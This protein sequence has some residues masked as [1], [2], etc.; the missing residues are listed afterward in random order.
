MM[1]LLLITFVLMSYSAF[2]ADVKE[3]LEK[4]Q[5]AYSTRV[6]Y[7]SVYKLYKTHKS[8]DVHSSYNGEVYG[9]DGLLYQKIK[10]TEFVYAKDF[11][12]KVSHE[13]RAMVLDM[14]QQSAQMEANLNK[15]LEQCSSSD[16]IEQDDYYTLIFRFKPTSTMPCSI[17]KL[18]VDKKKYILQ[19]MDIYYSYMQDFSTDYRTKDLSMPHLRVEFKETNLKPKA[20]EGIFEMATYLKSNKSMLTP[21][22]KCTGYELIDNRLN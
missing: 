4:V 12:I 20:R 3:V 15:A 22:G 5:Q 10:N 19:R 18:R 6:S 8:R 17:L 13:E 11:F 1:R 21:V 9:D 2:G 7:K 16:I 14:A